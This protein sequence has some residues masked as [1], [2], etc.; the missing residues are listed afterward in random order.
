MKGE[1]IQNAPFLSIVMPTYNRLYAFRSILF[2]GL[3]KQTYSDYEV[4]VVDDGSNDGTAD[5]FSLEIVECFPI[6]SGRIRYFRNESNRGAP[7]SRNRGAEEARGRWI[8]VLEDDIQID[9][10][11]YL[12]KAVGVLRE[13]GSDI[14]VVSPKRLES[15]ATGYYRNPDREF[16]RIGRMSGEIYM[17]PNQEY[18]GFVPNTH[19][20]S[21]IR[22]N[23]FLRYKEDE[24]VFFGNTF[25][26]ESDL[27]FRIAKSGKKI[28]YVGDVLRTIH[29]NDIAS[30]GG[31]KKINSNSLLRRDFMEIRNH[32]RYLLK[33]GYSVPRLR[34]AVYSC[35][36]WSR[37]ISN[38]LGV[39]WLK[40]FSALWKI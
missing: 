8:Y 32:F 26:D 16:V 10:P 40:N 23:D 9:D 20:S 13:A 2:P 18:T 1:M 35:V 37:H 14:A 17:D 6:L 11:D 38:I 3:E 33:N 27:Y 22:K 25:R 4:I 5:F 24:E 31:Q 28:L 29:R 7:A 30:E 21:F 36:R 15:K 12:M 34:T 39:D 19:A